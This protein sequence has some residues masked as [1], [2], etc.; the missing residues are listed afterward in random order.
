[1]RLKTIYTSIFAAIILV[2][3]SCGGRV[4][5]NM[6]QRAAMRQ[7]L[8]DYRQMVY[9]ANLSSDDFVIFSDGVVEDIELDYPIYT[10]FIKLPSVS[11]T[12]QLYVI[13]AI[14]D[15]LQAD[16]AN[17]RYL[18]PYAQLVD[19]G[20]LPAE[21]SH[22]ERVAFYQ[23]MANKVNNNYMGFTSFVN[24]LI[25]NEVSNEQLNSFISDCSADL[26]NWTIIVED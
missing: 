19:D 5:W 16:V 8:E 11:D 1:M 24:S 10:E 7:A 12:V 18:M 15:E 4:E 3:T 21:L 9:L 26:F 14:V 17:M 20:M 22:S 25:E 2:A 23:C 6:Q 13:T